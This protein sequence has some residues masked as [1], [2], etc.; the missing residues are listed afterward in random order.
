MCTKSSMIQVSVGDN[1][2]SVFGLTWSPCPSEGQLRVG[3]VWE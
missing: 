3:S 2:L 1:Y